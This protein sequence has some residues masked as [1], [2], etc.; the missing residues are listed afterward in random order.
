MF[1]E[2]LSSMSVVIPHLFRDRLETGNMPYTQ[3]SWNVTGSSTMMIKALYTSAQCRIWSEIH[4]QSW[5]EQSGLLRLLVIRAVF[6]FQGMQDR[7]MVIPSA[8]HSK[9]GVMETQGD[10]L[11]LIWNSWLA[12]L[13]SPV[14]SPYFIIY[15]CLAFSMF[16]L[17]LSEQIELRFWNT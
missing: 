16:R 15:L 5:N 11:K 8:Y 7:R 2:E 17:W 13:E 12:F 4:L 9:E 6:C 14:S 3:M 10:S 1:S